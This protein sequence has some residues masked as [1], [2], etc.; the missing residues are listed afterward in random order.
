M[1]NPLPSPSFPLNLSPLSQFVCQY[2]GILE[3]WLNERVY[4]HMKKVAKWHSLMRV[5]GVMDF[6]RLEEICGGYQHSKGPGTKPKY[7][8]GQ[9]VRALFVKY[10][11]GWS[12]RETEERMQHDL[13]V[14]WFV[15]FGVLEGVMD[16]SALCLFEQWVEE[17][18][19]RAYFDE[20]LGQID[21]DIPEAD[22]E[23][24][25][26]DTYG[27][28]AR[29]AQES[30]IQLLRHTTRLLLGELERGD[31]K[32]YAAILLQV[33]EMDNWMKEKR[34]AYIYKM[35]S[36]EIAQFRLEAGRLAWKVYQQVAAGQEQRRDEVKQRVQIRLEDLNKILHDE[37]D[38]KPDGK[39]EL[40]VLE[41]K[42]SKHKGEFRQCSANDPDATCRNHGGEKIVGY[43]VS[44]AVTQLGFVRE[45]AAATGAEPDRTGIPELI[46]AQQQH[47]YPLPKKLIYDQAGGTGRTRAVVEQ[48]SDGQTQLVAKIPP[49]T[50]GGRF[51]PDDFHFNEAGELVCPQQRT[52]SSH[53]RSDQ[54]DGDH[55]TF[56]AKCCSGCPLWSQCREPDA[57]PKGNRNVFISDYREHIRQA[58]AYN[59]SQDFQSDMK[60]RPLVERVIFM[61]T[62][63][64]HARFASTTGL[65]RA[66]FQ[67]KMAASMR[68]LRTWINLRLR[69]SAPL[70]R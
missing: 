10:Y 65:H 36:E 7:R 24:Q 44:L 4:G 32:G 12:Y 33:P 39:N 70:P 19:H 67:V 43:N 27:M 66:D 68:N 3:Q 2:Q 37:F 62:H 48:L 64:D 38:I 26:G 9:Y 16:H 20:V 8:I 29:A 52:T 42:D 23:V 49:P 35:K 55:F 46:S 51:T 40:Q 58:Q 21:R 45:I 69:R 31:A 18:C 30:L 54:R 59:L 34:E 14:K 1:V 6:R 53:H 15:G 47:G 50:V 61:L 25:I 17:H 28:Y 57:S 22:G 60:L 41:E 56:S 63:Y 5:E 13:V 11:Y